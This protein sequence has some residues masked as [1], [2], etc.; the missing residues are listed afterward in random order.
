MSSERAASAAR[1]A[2]PPPIVLED[3]SHAFGRGALRRQ[4][5]FD[6]SAEVREGEIVL[7]TGPSGSGK[8]TLLTLVGAL[9]ATQA[10]SLRV[11]G[12]E[13][14]GAGAGTLVRLRRQMGY[15]FQSHNLIESL[16]ARENVMMA[17]ELKRGLDAGNR[18]RRA[19][20][21]LAA[22]GLAERADSPPA[23]L[24][25]GQ[26]QRVAV[27]RA[28]APRPR[29]VLADEPTA[30]LDKAT[31][32]EVIEILRGLARRD[33]VTVLLVTHDDRIL[34]VADRILHLEDGRLA[35][36]Y[37]AAV[38]ESAGNLMASLA[39]SSLEGRLAEQ[40][41]DLPEVRFRELLEGFTA[42]TRSFLEA[43]RLSESEAYSGM[44]AQVLDVFTRKI[45]RLLDADRAS[46]FLVDRRRGE[47][48]SKYAGSGGG[49]PLEIRLPLA[50][51]TVAGAVAESGT[52]LNVEDAYAHPLFDPAT[53][54]RTGYRTRSLL[55]VPIR[56]AAGDVIAVA[57]V[58]NKRGGGPFS[59][60]D[61]RR[62]A[63]LA[64]AMGVILESWGEMRR[65]RRRSGREDVRAGP[66]RI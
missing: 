26:R 60:R 27:A 58:L 34:D 12:T 5:L 9:R 51:P 52:G 3:V 6:V 13:L 18:R 54:R 56:G 53:D 14:R 63:E 57:E 42:E 30:S 48:W 61:E 8:T 38:A 7:F 66:S 47:L 32:R 36:S 50:E 43:V 10:G 15:I 16:T 44:L 28:L 20:E 17:L 24:S 1:P 33:G 55:C 46:L 11:L 29:I 31:G 59:D 35:T 37:A 4:V 40:V 21:T 64:G 45:G 19:E 25:G 49:E 2:Q 23:E 41:E 62:L 22:V 65:R 39:R